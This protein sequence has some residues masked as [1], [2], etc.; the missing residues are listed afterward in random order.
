MSLSCHRKL[1]RLVIGKFRANIQENR[2]RTGG[3]LGSGGAVGKQDG[4]AI[5][6]GI[7]AAA[8]GA[9][10]YVRILREGLAADRADEPAEVFGLEG[11]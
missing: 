8:S 6:D 7:A 10:H 1:R 11:H 4:D 9:A 3:A 2:R 5:D